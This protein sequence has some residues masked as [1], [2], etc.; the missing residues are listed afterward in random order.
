MNR[1]QFVKL[2]IYIF[3]L[4]LGAGLF[5]FVIQNKNFN[6]ILNIIAKADPKWIVA[7]VLISLL[8]HIIRALRWHMLIEANGTSPSKIYTYHSMMFGYLVN[9]V[10]PRVGELTRCAALRKR[11]K[12]SFNITFGTVL[13]DKILDMVVLTVIIIFV[14]TTYFR[15]IYQI[16]TKD[17]PTQFG[18]NQGG[19]SQLKYYIIAS[20]IILILTWFLFKKRLGNTG[21]R[22]D[23]FLRQVMKGATSIKKVHKKWLLLLYTILIWMCYFLMSYFCFLSLNQ[24]MGFSPMIV[25]IIMALGGIARAV[26][27]PAGAMGAYHI[28]VSAAIVH[29][30]I[31]P[32]TDYGWEVG[33]GLATIIHGLQ[34]LF[35]LTFG[36]L[37][38][39]VVW[40]QKV[41]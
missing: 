7:V 1:K 21:K 13:M 34:L 20:L 32:N 30:T 18:T 17:I 40:R 15:D 22:I 36:G 31:L 33:F 37:S 2:S 26:P 14:L 41:L 5:F 29:F 23:S 19:N 9:I 39:I 12:I 6:N 35:Y 24:T 38:S 3:F 10:A 8:C 11:N 27:I 16:I 28:I 25:I 4:A